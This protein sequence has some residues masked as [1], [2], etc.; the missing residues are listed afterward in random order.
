LEVTALKALTPDPRLALACALLAFAAGPAAARDCWLRCD[1]APRCDVALPSAPPLQ[2]PAQFSTPPVPC[3][4]LGLVEQGDR[5]EGMV[6]HRGK[7]QV[8]AVARQQDVGAAVR[9]FGA[10]EC[11]YSDR[12]CRERRDQGMLAGRAGKAFDGPPG[13][14]PT[15]TPCA[16]GLPCG[17]VLAPAQPWSL[18]IDDAQ[19]D[20]GTLQIAALRNASGQIDVPVR[21]GR[22]AVA[23]GFVRAGASYSYALT[24]RAGTVIAAGQFSAA[25][26]A[27]ES[28]VQQAEQAARA[29]GRSVAAA[30]LEAL[31]ANE[32]D[33]DVMLLTRP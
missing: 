8:F 26:P 31:L 11:S 29:A 9:Q 1:G 16:I 33:W 3:A 30:R 19:A 14:K 2:V 10:A 5:V 21:G 13:H 15:G 28:D 6:R 20:G 23:P 24:S 22:A 27:I 4:S 25:A 12:A 32:L 7:V 18:R 17:V